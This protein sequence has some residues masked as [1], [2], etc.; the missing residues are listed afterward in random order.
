MD[1][2]TKI[3]IENQGQPLV[4]CAVIHR[5][6]DGVV[7]ILIDLHSKN[8]DILCYG[9]G[10]DSCPTL[11]ISANEKSLY[12]NANSKD[13]TTTIRFDEFRGWSIWASE[14]SRYSIMLCLVYNV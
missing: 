5:R 12:L 8:C 11:T 3:T 7:A 2:K 13:S 9:S 14:I 10:G 6:G 4:N 1:E